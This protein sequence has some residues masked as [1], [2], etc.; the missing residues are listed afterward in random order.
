MAKDLAYAFVEGER[1]GVRL[2]TGLAA[3]GQFRSAL[4]DGHGEQDM[5]AVI[6]PLREG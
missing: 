6:E 1:H 4:A 3:L 5:S 2:E